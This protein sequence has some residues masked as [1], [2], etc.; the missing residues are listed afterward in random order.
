M[1]ILGRKF[2]L[3]YTLTQSIL[4]SVFGFSLPFFK[5]DIDKLEL[6]HRATEIV[7]GLDMVSHKEC[8]EK[9]GMFSLQKE[10]VMG[11]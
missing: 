10:R 6:I 9:T 4:E 7:K 11:L 1:V 2:A 3:L 8:L 5:R